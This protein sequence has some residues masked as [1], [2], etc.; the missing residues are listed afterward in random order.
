MHHSSLSAFKTLL[1]LV[2]RGLLLCI[3]LWICL[4]CVLEFIQLGSLYVYVFFHILDVFNHCSLEYFVSLTS[5]TTTP[6]WNTVDTNIRPSQD[7]PFSIPSAHS[8]HPKH[9]RH[10]C[11]PPLFLDVPPTTSLEVPAALR[12]ALLSCICWAFL[13]FS[14][15]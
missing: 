8:H 7:F 12:A 15:C 6:S 1:S 14:H 9:I 2:F 10:C 5:T 11:P 4:L 3:F 13:M